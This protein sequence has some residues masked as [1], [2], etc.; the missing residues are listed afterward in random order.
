MKMGYGY[1]KW[2]KKYKNEIAISFIVTVVAFGVM[3]LF[4]TVGIDEEKSLIAGEGYGPWIAQGRY[5]IQLFNELFTINGRYVPFLWDFLSILVWFLSGIV[6]AVTLLGDEEQRTGRFEVFWFLSYYATLPFVV[7]EILSFSMFNLQLSI[8]MLSAALSFYCFSVVMKEVENAKEHV[9]IYSILRKETFFSIFLLLYAAATYQ[10]I[11]SVFIAETVVYCLQRVLDCRKK[12]G[13]IIISAAAVCVIAA[14]GYFILNALV[15]MITNTPADYTDSYIGWFEDPSVLH[16]AFM[17]LANVIRVSF[18]ITIQDVSIYGGAVILCNTVLFIIWAVCRFAAAKGWRQKG[19]IFFLSVSLVVSPFLIYI[20]MGTY[21]THGRMLLALPLVG[22]AEL[23]FVLRDLRGISAHLRKR[24]WIYGMALMAACYLLWLNVRNMNTI[25]YHDYVR[26]QQDKVTAN[27]VMHDVA[28][29]GCDYRAKPIVFIGA[30]ESNTKELWDSSDNL[31]IEGSFLSWN[32]GHIARIREFL[33]LE[34]YM[35]IEPST[36]D[37]AY[38]LE[39]SKDMTQWPAKGSIKDT[40]RCIIVYFS[41]PT[42][43]WY[44]VNGIAPAAS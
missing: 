11:L 23:G 29:E 34:G 35:T 26:Y 3:L 41:E 24:R 38:A 13:L 17:A 32:G 10:A 6:C 37:I 22:A 42:E 7:G 36:E 28:T 40:E 9:N 16:A 31:G 12:T 2:L 14:A 39:N 21:K 27:E 43:D 8:G 20:C 1:S 19:M 25:Y 33:V 18:G 15:Q 5:A 4:P 30:Y 44:W